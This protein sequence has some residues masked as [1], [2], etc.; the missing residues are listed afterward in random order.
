MMIIPGSSPLHETRH[1]RELG[2][3]LDDVVREYQRT[4]PDVTDADVRTA[5]LRLAPDDYRRRG[6]GVVIGVLTALAFG[7]MASTGGGRY[8]PGSLGWRILA[9]VGAVA[10]VTIVAIRLARRA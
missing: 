2:R 6:L 9:I 5:L 7:V 8:A 4:N 3:L 1:S 10:G